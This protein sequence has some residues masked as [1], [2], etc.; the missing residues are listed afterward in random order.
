MATFGERLRIL[1][2]QKEL[3]IRKLADDLKYG[4]TTIANWENDN[5]FPDRETLIKLADFFNVTVDYLLGR[6]DNPNSFIQTMKYNNHDY[7]FELDKLVLPNGLTYE[8]MVEFIDELKEKNA[9]LE[10]REK[11]IKETLKED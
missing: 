6:T 1:R 7:E 8:E 3:S 5:R 11:I 9:K 2:Q 10:E 4:K